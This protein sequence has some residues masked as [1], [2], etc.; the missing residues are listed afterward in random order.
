MADQNLTADEPSKKE[1]ETDD[2]KE[3]AEVPVPY[4]LVEVKGATVRLYKAIELILAH[5]G[6]LAKN[7][8]DKSQLGALLLLMCLTSLL[9]AVPYGLIL[10]P[11]GFWRMLVLFLGSMLICFPSLHIFGDFLGFKI[12]LEQ[13]LALGFIIA[14]V[15]AIFSFGFFPIM[16]FLSLT[17]PG[18]ASAKTLHILS[19]A[20]L[21][22]SLAA[23]IIHYIRI[24]RL[25]GSLPPP[26]LFWPVVILWQGLL[27]FIVVRMG[28]FLEL[29]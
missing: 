20:F 25:L 28:I 13:N 24:V 7:I 17:M 26:E 15:A 23:G 21:I 4:T 18:E 16:G 8:Y 14:S 29:F 10:D 19:V 11:Q 1:S 3:K 6:R 22:T 12:K 2:I 5:P 9:F 27:I